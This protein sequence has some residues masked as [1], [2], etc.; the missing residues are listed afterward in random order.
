MGS[1]SALQP[2]LMESSTCPRE[3]SV[4]ELSEE[5]T[6]PVVDLE[7][8]FTE[9]ALLTIE[10]VQHQNSDASD[11]DSSGRSR[12]ACTCVPHRSALRRIPVRNEDCRPH[13]LRSPSGASPNRAVTQEEQR[14]LADL[15]L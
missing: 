5:P 14:T 8:T 11:S 2:D 9:A 6:P 12:R 10:Q 15:R 13:C 1:L 3:A 4:E 7:D